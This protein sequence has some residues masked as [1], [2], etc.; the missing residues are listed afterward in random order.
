MEEYIRSFREIKNKLA[1]LGA[2]IPV[3]TLIQSMLNGLPSS[4]DSLIQSVE[5]SA[6]L[7]SFEQL[8][9]KLLVEFNRLK[10]RAIQIG[11]EEALIAQLQKTNFQG[12]GKG[13][14]RG[15]GASNR[16]KGGRSG[17]TKSLSGGRELEYEG[18][19]LF[20]YVCGKTNHIARDC[21]FRKKSVPQNKG[22]VN[23]AEESKLES[24]K[25]SDTDEE[26]GLEIAFS[27]FQSSSDTSKPWFMD[28]GASRHVTGYKSSLDFVDHG[29]KH[30]TNI[31]T[32][33]GGN[34]SIKGKGAIKLTTSEGTIKLT[35]ALYVPSLQRNLVSVGA[36]TDTGNALLFCKSTVWVLNNLRDRKVI[37]IGHRD[38]SNGL[39]RM[40]N[41]T[42]DANSIT[43]I[44]S[45]ELWHRRYGHLHYRGLSHL[46]KQ[47]Q[48][49]GLPPITDI[50][51]NC[52][53]CLA[54]RQS[55][56]RFPKIS[57]HR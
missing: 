14:N 54:G 16:G 38:K 29:T 13:S 24:S 5:Q 31:R 52:E 3:G 53:D 26:S 19:H 23:S 22:S 51:H 45:T 10:A 27:E 56:E 42:L 37:A 40:E 39:Y 55:R 4:Y 35:D 9:A 47:N 15:R 30:E 36:L 6:A 49:I 32:A 43:S 33:N 57:S 12:K 48:V 7:P 46:Y 2:P 28:S 50:Q 34:H 44:P 41:R 17:S 20:C 1:S 25:E 18:Q 11:D 21:F 8:G